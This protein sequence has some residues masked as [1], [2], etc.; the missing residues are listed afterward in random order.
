MAVEVLVPLAAAT[1][2]L[3]PAWRLVGGMEALTGILMCAWSTGVSFSA[4]GQLLAR[5]SV[6]HAQ[7]SGE[8]TE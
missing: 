2:A 6:L 5:K 8:G 4:L 1:A 7:P 3:P